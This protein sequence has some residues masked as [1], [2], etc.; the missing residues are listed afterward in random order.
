MEIY[1]SVFEE[2]KSNRK[3]SLKER[4]DKKKL[5]LFEKNLKKYK[6]GEVIETV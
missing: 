2:G 1:E 4:F 6:E 3:Q 5:N